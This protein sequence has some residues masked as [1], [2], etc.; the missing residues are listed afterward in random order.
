M[1]I[2]RWRVPKGP[3]THVLMDGGILNVPTHET[4]EF[5]N[6]CV[7]MFPTTKLFVV[8]QKTDNFKFFVDLDYKAPTKLN[9]DDLLR[10]CTI[11][12]EAVGVG[13]CLI[14]R[15]RPRPIAEGL[16]KS[17]VH[18]HWPDLVVNRVQALNYRSKIIQNL[19]EGPW[20]AVIDASVY[21][22]SGLRMLWSHKKPTGD[23]YV[24]WRDL[25]GGELPKTPSADTIAL[26]AVRTDEPP[27][28]TEELAECSGI[29]EYIQKYMAGQEMAKVCK[30]Q[31]HEFDG[32]F[33]QTDSKYCENIRCEHKSNHVWFSIRAGRIS[34]RCFD[35]DCADFVGRDEFILPTPL[36]EQLNG[37]VIVGSPAR[38]FDRDVS[39][40]YKRSV[41]ELRNGGS[42]F[43]GPGPGDLAELL[44]TCPRVRTVGFNE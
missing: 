36:V 2:S 37:V 41:Q 33:V 24:P 25:A 18:I 8:E 39:Q 26:F 3:A 10:F 9:D 40:G 5:Y 31:R 30:V 35:E 44:K 43:F 34:Q 1:S 23:P 17:G 19:G 15:A 27:R 32:W 29:Q 7:A 11:I 6:E 14:A 21:S 12:H 16:V 20:D 4:M 22:G 13:R 42:S 28:P 38:N